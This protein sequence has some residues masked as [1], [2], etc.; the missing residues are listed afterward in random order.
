MA[1]EGVMSKAKEPKGPTTQWGRLFAS[2]LHFIVAI[3]L[4]ISGPI[5]LWG[6]VY[7][8]FWIPLAPAQEI[9]LNYSMT[10]FAGSAIFL[11]LYSE[12]CEEMVERIVWKKKG[13]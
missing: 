7:L 3:L 9:L 13:V 4:F 8:L 10:I 11:L 6:Y 5:I 1:K 2:L 12:K